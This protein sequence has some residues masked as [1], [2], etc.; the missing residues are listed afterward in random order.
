MRAR[1]GA[2]SAWLVLA[3]IAIPFVVTGWLGLW[4]LALGLIGIQFMPVSP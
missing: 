2:R 3:L 1:L 4:K